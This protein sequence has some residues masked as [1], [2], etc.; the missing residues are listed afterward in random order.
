MS[1]NESDVRQSLEQIVDPERNKNAFELGLLQAARVDSDNG[2]LRVTLLLADDEPL[3]VNDHALVD[4]CQRAISAT[5]GVDRV[6]LL[7]P[8]QAKQERPAQPS[9][10][11][12]V[13]A[14]PQSA[15][16]ESAAVP[17]PASGSTP[18]STADETVSAELS[19]QLAYEELKKVI[20][21]ELFVNIYG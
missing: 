11:A 14:A 19:E 4:R 13:P 16:D 15:A 1:I 20:D 5:E 6:L 8:A 17:S 2:Q 21:P 10:A 12:D 7:S 3:R 9:P 18:D